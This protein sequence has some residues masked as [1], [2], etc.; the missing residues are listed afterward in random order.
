MVHLNHVQQLQNLNEINNYVH[1][2]MNHQIASQTIFGAFVRDV[3][4]AITTHA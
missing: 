3:V 1:F 2:A 4:T